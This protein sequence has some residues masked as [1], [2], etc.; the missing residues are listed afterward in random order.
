MANK[1]VAKVR[2]SKS[3]AL[4]VVDVAT[5]HLGTEEEAGYIGITDDDDI[6]DGRYGYDPTENDDGHSFVNESPKINYTLFQG[7]YDDYP[8][9]FHNIDDLN[10]E[11]NEIL[12]QPSS[13]HEIKD[14]LVYKGRKMRISRKG[15]IF[16]AEE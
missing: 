3:D 5:E 2:R 8:Q 10:E 7:E 4:D 14:L 16:Q 6:Y 13:M 1:K 15:E 11:I 12:Q 9:V